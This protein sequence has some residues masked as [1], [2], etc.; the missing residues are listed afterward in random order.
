MTKVVLGVYTNLNDFREIKMI[1][2]KL[3]V[4]KYGKKLLFFIHGE[5]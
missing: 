1:S 3:I 4:A 2:G 5:T